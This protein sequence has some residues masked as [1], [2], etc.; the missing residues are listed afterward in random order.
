M[1]S[2][3]HLSLYVIVVLGIIALP[4]M[5]M[6]FVMATALLGGRR[7]GM[8]AVAGIVAGGL[9]HLAMAG[10]G[11][12]AIL[13]GSP[14]LFQMMLIG[15]AAYITWMGAAFLRSSGIALPCHAG[16]LS[17][18]RQAFRRAMVTSLLNPKAYIFMFAIFPQFLQPS[19]GPLWIQAGMLGAITSLTQAGVYG[20]L[21]LAAAASSRWLAGHPGASLLA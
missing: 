8:A 20:A 6:A 11:I 1:L 3:A 15:G 18:P 16:A 13:R 12:V 10:L 19:L 4:G 5:D 7:A 14:A 2:T 21:A 17:S 9:C